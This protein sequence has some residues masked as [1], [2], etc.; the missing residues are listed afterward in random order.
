M[1]TKKA[2]EINQDFEK[3]FDQS[4][5][6]E[7]AEVQVYNTPGGLDDEAVSA[8]EAAG[9]GA[10][11]PDL[12]DMGQISEETAAKILATPFAVA[13][14]FL[15]DHWKLH[16]EEIEIMAPSASRVFTE[17]FGKYASRYPDAYM[18]GFSLCV[19]VG[20]RAAITIAQKKKEKEEKYNPDTHS[21]T[22]RVAVPDMRA[23]ANGI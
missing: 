23:A 1:P 9:E 20:A 19:C 2:A 22:A 4:A 18:L 7:D 6:A 8:D 5:A 13:A 15:G 11:A 14:A 10:A 12:R 16:K 3:A 21:D 17:M